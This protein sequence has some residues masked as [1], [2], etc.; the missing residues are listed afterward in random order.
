[1]SI[2]RRKFVKSAIL[3]PAFSVS[4]GNMF[5]LQEKHKEFH[6]VRPGDKMWPAEESWQQL[7]KAV[8]ET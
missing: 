3:L 6:R 5:T 1:M 4:S 7:N 2:S 8:M